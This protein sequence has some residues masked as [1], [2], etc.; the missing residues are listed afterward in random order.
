MHFGARQTLLSVRGL[1][2]AFIQGRAKFSMANGDKDSW[3]AA[4]SIYEFEAKDI[5]GNVVPLEKY[6]GHVCLIV[7]VASK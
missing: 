1:S 2:L 3:K 7:N 5:D 4:Q 6:K